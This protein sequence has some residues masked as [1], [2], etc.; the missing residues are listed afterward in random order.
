MCWRLCRH[1][2]VVRASL[3]IFSVLTVLVQRPKVVR[4]SGPLFR[5]FSVEEEESGSSDTCVASLHVGR[6][7]TGDAF[8]ASGATLP[9]S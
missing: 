1:H 4:F 3:N 9:T 7:G 5:C 8:F 6:A 2:V